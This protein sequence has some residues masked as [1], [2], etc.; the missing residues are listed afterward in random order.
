V[1]SAVTGIVTFLIARGKQRFGRDSFYEGKITALMEAQ[2]KK[3]IALQEEVGRL[4]KINLELLE[5]VIHLE[6]E[7][8]KHDAKITGTSE[9]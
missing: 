6:G 5:K 8:S 9:K 1:A 2:E 3:I 4:T 7:L